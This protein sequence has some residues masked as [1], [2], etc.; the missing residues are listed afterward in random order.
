MK[1]AR[2]IVALAIAAG[3]ASGFAANSDRDAP[4]SNALVNPSSKWVKAPDWWVQEQ[5]RVYDLNHAG[6]PQ[7]GN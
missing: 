7:Y 6:F 2:L 4:S 1:A 5:E 3:S